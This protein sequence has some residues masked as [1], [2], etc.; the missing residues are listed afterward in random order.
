MILWSSRSGKI[1]LCNAI[2]AAIIGVEGVVVIHWK[3]YAKFFWSDENFLYQTEVRVTQVYVFFGRSNYI[4][5]ICISLYVP[6]FL[7]D[8]AH[9]CLGQFITPAGL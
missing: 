9:C 4:L 3:E 5:N 7:K 6:Q 1:N 8:T 2:R